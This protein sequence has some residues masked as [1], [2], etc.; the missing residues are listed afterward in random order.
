MTPV[1][2]REQGDMLVIRL[3]RPAALLLAGFHAHTC[4]ECHEHVP[5][6][7]T[8]HCEPDQT[9]DDGRARGGYSVCDKCEA[10]SPKDGWECGNG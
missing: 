6:A 9:L 8:C 2:N 3:D 5:C 10:L 7:M 4:P 1:E